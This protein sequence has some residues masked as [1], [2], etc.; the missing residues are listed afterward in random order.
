MRTA[1]AGWAPAG[2][3]PR[4]A[5]AAELARAVRTVDR[6]ALVAGVTGLLANVLLVVLLTS[7][8]DGPYAWTGPANDVVGD[9]SNLATIPVAVGLLAVCGHRRGL[10]AITSL[11]IVAMAV[12]TTVSMLMVL[13]LVPFAAGTDSAYI[14]M[15]FLFGWVFAAGRAGRASGRLPRQLAGWGV[16]IGAAGL[17]GAALLTASA[18]LPAHSLAWDI[19]FGAGWLTAIPVALFPV[20][21]IVLSYRLPGHLA[22]RVGSARRS[23]PREPGSRVSSAASGHMV[24]RGEGHTA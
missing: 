24:M 18:P 6:W 9:V 5:T 15:I 17:A 12:M 11:A 19:T 16:A 13:G 1:S 3:G 21:L 4:R 14:G 20:W 2:T 22:D 8:T 23:S 7:P 10:G